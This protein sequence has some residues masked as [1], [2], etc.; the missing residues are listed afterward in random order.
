MFEYEFRANSHPE[1]IHYLK[2]L[3]AEKDDIA[4]NDGEVFIFSRRNRGRPKGSKDRKGR[5]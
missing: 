4:C 1:R 3:I 2:K 5:R